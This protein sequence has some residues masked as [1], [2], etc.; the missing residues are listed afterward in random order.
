MFLVSYFKP[1]SRKRLLYGLG[2]SVLVILVTAGIFASNGWFPSTDSL[3][4]K[5]KGWFGAELPKNAPSSW[6]PIAMPSATPT[7]QLS[8]EYLYAGSRLLAVED[9]NASAAPPSDL[10]IWRPSTGVWWVRI[11]G[12]SWITHTWGVSGDEPVPGDFDGDGTTDFSVWRSSNQKWYVIH[13]STGGFYEYQFGAATDV[14]ASADYDGDGKTDEAVFRPSNGTWYIHASTAG[15]YTDSTVSAANDI[16]APADY[17]G[18]GKADLGT[19]RETDRKF[20]SKNSSNGST[21]EI[22]PNFN[23]SNALWKTVS[24]DYDGDGKADY[25]VY[26]KYNGK[27]YIRSSITGEY[28]TTPVSWGQLGD[29]AVPNDYDADSRCD[30]AVWRPGNGTWYIVESANN[31]SMREVPWGQSGDHPVPA[32]YRR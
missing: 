29:I 6:N 10:A 19:F 1:E 32:F 20:R 18:D 17:D 4:G 25:A 31:Y 30:Y 22:S 23:P 28:P 24:A 12:S 15:Y 7:P 27:W 8:K 14:P 26:D 2:A 21:V 5:R 11:S 3:S 13:S 9:K 16:P